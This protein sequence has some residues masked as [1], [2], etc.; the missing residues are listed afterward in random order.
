MHAAVVSVA[1]IAWAK[2][3]GDGRQPFGERQ[4][5]GDDPGGQLAERAQGR[6]GQDAG[7][8]A[9]GEGDEHPGELKDQCD[10]GHQDHAGRDR[11]RRHSLTGFGNENKDFIPIP[12][13]FHHLFGTGHSPPAGGAS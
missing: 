9:V 1:P 6:A 7:P 12:Y 2:R 5:R 4:C 3:L 8:E 13:R 11:A 10:D